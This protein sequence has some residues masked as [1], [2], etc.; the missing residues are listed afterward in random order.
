MMQ[1]KSGSAYLG[2]NALNPPDVTYK[3][4]AP[5]NNDYIGYDLMH[6]WH[7]ILPTTPTTYELWYLA[8]K[9]AGYAT[10][11]RMYPQAGGGGGGNLRSDDTEI[12]Y[13]D[14][15]VYTA[16]NVTGGQPYVAGTDTLLNDALYANIFTAQNPDN[17]TLQIV[18]KRSIR[19]PVGTADGARGLYSIGGDDFMH[20]YGTTNTMLGIDA[21]NRTLIFGA[22]INNTCIGYNTLQGII[23]SY[24]CTGL[25]FN[26][27]PTLTGGAYVIAIGQNAGTNY[28]ANESSNILIGNPGVAAENNVIRI[29][30]MGNADGE[31]NQCFLAGVWNSPAVPVINTG[32]VVVDDSGQLYVDDLA[33]DSVVMTDAGGNPIAVKGPKGTIL[34]GRGLGGADPAP[35]FLELKSA[36][37]TVGITVTPGGPDVDCINL[38]VLPAAGGIATLTADTGVVLPLLA[39][40]NIS[41]GELIST[42]NLVAHTVTVNLNRSANNPL[43]TCEIIAGNGA[44]SPSA[45]KEIYSSDGSLDFDFTTDPTKIDVKYL[46]APVP[47]GITKLNG[48]TGPSALPVVG[49]ID[50]AGSH[51]IYTT[52]SNPVPGDPGI[53]EVF[54]TNDVDITG[55]LHAADEIQTTGLGSSLI[56]D[57]GHVELPNTDAG[58]VGGTIRFHDVRW[59]SNLG[60]NNT[61]VG[62]NSGSLALNILSAKDCTFIGNNV[63]ALHTNGESCVALGAAAFDVNVSGAQ[64][65]TIGVNAFGNDLGS[66][67]TTCLG[68]RAGYAATGINNNSCLYIDNIGVNGESNCIRIGTNGVAAHNQD[69]CYIAGIYSGSAGAA[70]RMVVCGSNHKLSTQAIP[71]AGAVTFHT[72]GG[73]AVPTVLGVLNVSGGYNATSDATVN[74]IIIDVDPSIQQDITAVDGSAGVYAMGTRGANTYATNRFMH[75]WG[76]GTGM[77]GG[78]TSLGFQAGHINALAIGKNNTSVGYQALNAYTTAGECVAIGSNSLGSVIKSGGNVAIGVNAGMALTTSNDAGYYGNNILIGNYAGSTYTTG[79]RNIEIGDGSSSALGGA[80]EYRTMR[81]GFKQVWSVPPPTPDK[82]DPVETLTLHGT[83]NTYCYGIY[84]NTVAYSGTPVYVD[85]LGKLGTEG[86]VMFAFRQTTG[87]GG[88]TGD[89]TVYVFGTSG[90]LTEDFDNTNSLIIGGAGAPAV[91][92]APYAGKYVFTASITMSVP[93]S[94]P[95]PRPVAVDPLY[96]VTSNLSFC[97]TNFMPAS[98]TVVQYVSEIV[99]TVVFLDAGDTV[100]WACSAGAAANAKNIG[101][102]ANLTPTIPGVGVTITYATYF[103]GYKVS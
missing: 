10:W 86:G 75:A 62:A 80:A 67:Y 40:I 98:T 20:A 46:G 44:A 96:I 58:D 93:A 50:I 9:A 71:A 19:Q 2:V 103:T 16:I 39:N 7:V 33:G 64:C 51:N 79:Y 36:G 70:P 45:Y 73:D 97:Y 30:V 89:G 11:K 102:I 23:T 5:T 61:F 32:L 59:I 90:G 92:T 14:A 35:T 42:D 1:G 85:H 8:N 15:T 29:G 63:G 12:E 99:T 77:A 60:T 95:V 49:E 69:K 100:R 76:G 88:A 78:N 56:T 13:P 74:T 38:E 26:V 57:L 101:I 54:L 52:S 6:L 43:L 81:L 34:T 27:L 72:S 47:G 84:K 22:A 17:N 21:G 87:V 28:V 3:D 31:Q 66:S 94:P 65:T 91:F 24:N 37:G 48:D 53:V 4:Y 82:P 41:H 55:W 83:D 18:L 68:W 25:G